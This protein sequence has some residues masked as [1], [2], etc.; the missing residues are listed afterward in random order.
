M[1]EEKE[2]ESERRRGDEGGIKGSEGYFVSVIL[3][4]SQCVYII[5]SLPASIKIIVYILFTLIEE[6]KKKKNI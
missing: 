3:I 2:G 6:A 5:L 1:G 4:L